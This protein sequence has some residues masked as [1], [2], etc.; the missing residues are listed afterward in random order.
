MLD[1]LWITTNIPKKGVVEVFPD[2]NVIKSS[3][4]M[5]RGGDFYAIWVED[6]GLWSTDED[7]AIKLID[8]EIENKARELEEKWPDFVIKRKFL[9]SS[10]SGMIDKFHRYC[11]HQL[12]DNFIPLDE[13]LI[14]S[15]DNPTKD[16]YSSKRLN[17]P[18]EAGPYDAWDKL[19]GTLYSEA[20][21][22][23]IE[24][25]IGAIVT[26]DSKTIQKFLVFYGS[27]G[28]GKSTVL[29]VIEKL[30]ANYTAVF[31]AKALGSN[32]GVF[33]LEAFKSNPLVAIQHDGDLSHIEDNTR[34]NSLVSHETMMVN[35]K[36][37]SAYPNSFKAF[38]FMGTN[39]P[40]KITD[41][42]SGLMRR[43]I[44][45][46]PSGKKIPIN[47]YRKLTKQI[48][49]E[50]GA[51][52]WH[53]KEVYLDSVNEYDNYIPT[54]MMGASNDFYNF[55]IDNY[56]TFLKNNSTTQKAAW[57]LY[58]AYCDD[59]KVSYPYSLR[60]F[61]E[62][63]KN[64]FWEFHERYIL[65]DGTRVRSYYSG[66]RKD[67]FFEE[68]TSN[69]VEKVVNID[70]NC[71]TSLL[72]DILKDCPAQLAKDDGTPTKA[73]GWTK[74]KLSDIDTRQVHYV[75]F[76]DIFPNL[77]CVDFDLKDE[78]GNKSYEL[79]LEA[80]SKWPKTYAELSKSGAGIHLYYWYNGDAEKLNNLY[81]KDIEIK[82]F[83]GKSALR[84]KVSRCNDIPIATISSGLPLKEEGDV[85][86]SESK[87]RS[88]RGIRTMI[89][90]NL[91]KEIHPAT[92]PSVDFIFKILSDA[93][94]SGVRYD[95]SDMY[96]DVVAFAMAS[97][98]QAEACM[99]L[100]A[101]MKFKSDETSENI[102]DDSKPIIFFD[103]EIFPNLFL[104][105]WKYQG[106]EQPVVRMFN[107][108]PEQ[109]EELI[110]NN[111]LIGFNN[112][113]YDNILL[114][115]RMMGYDIFKCYELSQKI[116]SH[117]GN[118]G[119]YESR[120]VSYTDVFDFSTKKQGLKKWEIELGVPH[121]ELGLPWDQPAPEEMWEEV[122]RYCD[123]DV[124]ATEAVF[125]HLKTD[126]KARQI[127]ADLAGGTVNESTNALTTKLVFGNEKKPMLVYTDLATGEQSVG[128]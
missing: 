73:W 16:D 2:Y 58:K 48:D 12:R 13:K 78:E 40:V 96:D 118:L 34:L 64:Y 24:W 25:A 114:W 51:I 14:F 27:A 106:K 109:V 117:E 9:R 21:R 30:F 100:V 107:P 15:N 125:N 126:W 86:V 121:K 74:T 99:K 5:I 43:L 95:V 42:K 113:K 66:F 11:Q 115:A 72:D 63:L 122:A 104:I 97:T 22:H 68:E 44:D 60:V 7:D 93:Y 81:S 127:L 53:C 57:E 79:N 8:R 26:G 56:S 119:M 50:L 4:L 41:A 52:A 35:E 105:C 123:N 75:M 71:T 80:A 112:L 32:N 102:E 6:R 98:H 55:V 92:K 83:R 110:T 120:N 77:I 3:D 103:I 116:I 128:R 84:R 18:L 88:E 101:K 94:E 82:V 17:Y 111:R 65:E 23:K 38:L 1:F 89:E 90:R 91:R 108:K 124:I 45:V 39:R 54:S 61:R 46:T 76:N 49:F 10:S 29:N 20:E 59:A 31:D 70:F 67:K 37:K 85:I 47:E 36:Y 87:I 19:V 62:E 28:T 33:A 69:E